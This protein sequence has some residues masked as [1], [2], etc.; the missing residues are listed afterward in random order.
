MSTTIDDRGHLIRT[1]DD[2][3]PCDMGPLTDE[4]QALL[5]E[6]RA[7]Q[8]RIVNLERIIATMHAPI[9]TP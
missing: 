9:R 2:G 8:D 7:L 4:S 6:I 1:H 3:T 5:A